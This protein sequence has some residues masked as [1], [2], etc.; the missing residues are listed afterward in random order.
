MKEDS[1]AVVFEAA[2]TP[3]VGLDRLNLG[4]EA[5][6]HRVGDG[7]QDVVQ[8][9]VQMGLEREPDP[10]GQQGQGRSMFT[11]AQFRRRTRDLPWPP[12]YVERC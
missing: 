1:I 11:C 4:V 6:R 3:G 5:F 7:M 9:P 8:Q 10:T 12:A 2:E